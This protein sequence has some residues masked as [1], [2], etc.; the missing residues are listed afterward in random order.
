MVPLQL[1]FESREK[2]RFEEISWQ[3][4]KKKK[5]KKKQSRCIYFDFSNFFLNIKI[6]D[7]YNFTKKLFCVLLKGTF[8]D[9]LILTSV[10]TTVTLSSWRSHYIDVIRSMVYF[11]FFPFF[12]FFF[13]RRQFPI[14]TVKCKCKDR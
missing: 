1:P 14:H 12:F 4:K 7:M 3:S 8:K 11:L 6:R 9:I 10:T 5:K 2:L 13:E